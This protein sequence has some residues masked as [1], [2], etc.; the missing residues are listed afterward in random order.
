MASR[1]SLGND[2][3]QRAAAEEVEVRVAA[4]RVPRSEI[5]ITARKAGSARVAAVTTEISVQSGT[6]AQ[7]VKRPLAQ[8]AREH[9]AHHEYYDQAQRTTAKAAEEESTVKL[10]KEHGTA[11]YGL[12]QEYY[13]H[14]QKGTEKTAKK[15]STVN[16]PDVWAKHGSL[17]WA[18]P[19]MKATHDTSAQLIMQ[20]LA[21]QAS[22]ESTATHRT[23]NHAQKAATKKAERAPAVTAATADRLKRLIS[24]Q[25]VE[26]ER[27]QRAA[28]A[29]AEQTP[30]ASAKAPPTNIPRKRQ[31]VT[32]AERLKR[33][34]IEEQDSE[35]GL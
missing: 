12:F 3:T 30:P 34:L 15:A 17:V 11:N 31:H 22:K 24:E 16:L 33:R 26:Y 32:T 6:S 13:D 23:N 14:A 9:R 21:Q 29:V 5:G 1:S 2:R 27:A 18:A 20:L 4:R 19:R 10:A 28:A 35:Y 8:T 25:D 7:R